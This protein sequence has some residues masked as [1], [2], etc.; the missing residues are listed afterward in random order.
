MYLKKSSGI[1]TLSIASCMTLKSSEIKNFLSWWISTILKSCLV[2]L[3]LWP[4]YS[5]TFHQD[6]CWDCTRF[7]PKIIFKS[8]EFESLLLL[9]EVDDHWRRWVLCCFWH[10]VSDCRIIFWLNISPLS[11][12]D[13]YG[14]FVDELAGVRLRG[15]VLG[16]DRL[17]KA[18]TFVFNAISS[19]CISEVSCSFSSSSLLLLKSVTNLF[20]PWEILTHEWEL[21]LFSRFIFFKFPLHIYLVGSWLLLLTRAQFWCSPRIQPFGSDDF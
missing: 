3:R 7:A 1:Y 21:S 10:W 17:A 13:G 5:S 14:F 16:F 18:S 11:F 4:S 2:G 6:Q 8:P 12:P 19:N 20:K 15:F 9:L